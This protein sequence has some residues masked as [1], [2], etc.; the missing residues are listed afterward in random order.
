MLSNEKQSPKF[1]TSQYRRHFL[2]VIVIFF[3][4]AISNSHHDDDGDDDSRDDKM[5]TKNTVR[6]YKVNFFLIEFFGCIVPFVEFIFN[7]T[8]KLF[9]RWRSNFR[10]FYVFLSHLSTVTRHIFLYMNRHN[11]NYDSNILHSFSFQLQ[12]K[13]KLIT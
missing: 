13:K 11:K 8:R 5:N 7:V 9:S 2:L 1:I 3:I 10:L 12:T 6:S 4:H